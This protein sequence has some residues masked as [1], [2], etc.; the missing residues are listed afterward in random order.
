MLRNMG[1]KPSEMDNLLKPLIDRVKAVEGQLCCAVSNCAL[2]D[3]GR[4]QGWNTPLSY[5]YRYASLLETHDKKSA[6]H[7]AK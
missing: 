7:L 6:E 1:V 4:W 3:S 2:S 5:V